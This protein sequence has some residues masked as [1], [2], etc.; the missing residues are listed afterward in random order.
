MS[1]ETPNALRHQGVDS[2]AETPLQV[3]VI[4]TTDRGTRAALR[5]AQSFA[6]GFSSH[7]TLVIPHTVPYRQPLDRPFVPVAFTVARFQTLTADLD[8][9][10]S[11]RV[12]ICRPGDVRFESVIPANGIVLVGGMRRTWWRSREQRLADQLSA[13]GRRVLFVNY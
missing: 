2:R 10:L 5:A 13:R 9:D 1:V 6:V 7:I 8:A 11:L 3:C 12:C 4:A